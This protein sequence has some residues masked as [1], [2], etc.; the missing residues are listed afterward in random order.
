MTADGSTLLRLCAAHLRMPTQ[1]ETSD[2]ATF[3]WSPALSAQEQA[4]FADLQ[5]MASFG[6]TASITLAEFQ[7]IKP[8]LVTARNFVAIA[9]PTQAQ[10]VAALKATI[11]IL[12][13]LLR[14]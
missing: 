5:I 2:P 6:L 9:S 1:Y 4:T 7:A 11:R 13:A 12:G 8:D 3:V 14:Q 10:S